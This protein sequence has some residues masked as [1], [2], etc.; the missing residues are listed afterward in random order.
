[1]MG[2]T[3]MGISSQEWLY[4]GQEAGTKL[5]LA[6]GAKLM[7]ILSDRGITAHCHSHLLKN[8]SDNCFVFG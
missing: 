6:S 3:M 2:V 8:S 4:S 5:Y 7:C 1:M